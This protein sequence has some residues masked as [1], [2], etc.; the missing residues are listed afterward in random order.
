M[1]LERIIIASLAGIVVGQALFV[2]QYQKELGDACGFGMYLADI[3][4]RNG[5]ELSEFDQIVFDQ[6]IGD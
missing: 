6:Y 5:V 1:N 3:I 4:D 2:R